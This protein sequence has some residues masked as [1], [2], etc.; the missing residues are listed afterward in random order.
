MLV[1]ALSGLACQRG[2]LWLV[3]A[4]ALLVAAP[5]LMAAL[6]TATAEL[7]HRSSLF[8]RGGVLRS[9]TAS[10]LLSTVGWTLWALFFG[11]FTVFWLHA[12][13]LLESTLL[14]VSMAVFPLF[15]NRV[16]LLTQSE[17]RAFYAHAAALKLSRLL[18]ALLMTPLYLLL[19]H[20]LAAPLPEGPLAPRLE[21]IAEV[22]LTGGHSLLIQL[23][24]KLF[25]YLRALQNFLLAA[26]EAGSAVQ[27]LALVVVA[28][29]L[30]YN[31]ALL[32][33]GFLVSPVEYRRVF[34]PVAATD[35]PGPASTAVVAMVAAVTTIVVVFLVLPGVAGVE[36][37]LK[38][39]YATQDIVANAE[40]ITVQYAE[41]ID[42]QLYRVGTLDEIQRTAAA[43]LQEQEALLAEIRDQS[44]RAFAQMRRNVDVYLDR[45]YSLPAEYL[46]IASALSGRLEAVIAD[47]LTEALMTGDAIAALDSRVRD[48][49][50]KA[51]Q[52]R[53]RYESELVA[54]LERQRIEAP[55]GPLAV[56][57][58]SSGMSPLSMTRP[59][60]GLMEFEQ[61]MALSGVSAIGGLIAAKT[62]SKVAAKGAIKMAAKGFGKIA[63]TKV[64][65]GPAGAAVG[66]VV[67][68][69]VPV[70]GTLVG[71]VIGFTVGVALGISVD[72]L[73]L[74]LEEFY[75]REDFKAQILQSIDEQEREFESLFAAADQ[76]AT[77]PPAT[78]PPVTNR[79]EG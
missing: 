7:I 60:A 69:M 42:G 22:P 27:W 54:I 33:S 66:A 13:T 72:A 49:L 53:Q 14:V 78:N 1:I 50:E 34:A 16:L 75:A 59:G 76:P 5:V 11:F 19:L 31:A 48:A 62:V 56:T 51:P 52:L 3:I 10:R 38:H 63:A 61:R 45:Y 67:G 35:D 20:F 18:Y 40:R 12:L 65:A 29:G 8:Q 26:P 9:I 55:S 74:E 17:M 47:E 41:R 71:S 36:Y 25:D 79:E 37:S 57:D 43:V 39:R 23:M 32:T 73:L 70:A 46:R 6:Y 15:F 64:A 77:N 68:S 44:R 4:V 24:V 30:F 28:F 58:G 21:T 2:E